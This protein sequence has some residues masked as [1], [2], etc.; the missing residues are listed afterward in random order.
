M[1]VNRSEAHIGSTLKGDTM[2]KPTKPVAQLRSALPELPPTLVSN[3]IE[4]AFVPANR[5]TNLMG[6]VA[7]YGLFG[8][9]ALTMTQVTRVNAAPALPVDTKTGDFVIVEIGPK[10]EPVQ[11]Q[12]LPTPKIT[13][14]TTRPADW[15]PLDV[16]N[17]VPTEAPTTVPTKDDSFSLLYNAKMPVGTG[18]IDKN[19]L[20]VLVKQGGA[21]VGDPVEPESRVVDFSYS[22]LRV[23]KQASLTYPPLARIARIQGPVVLVMTIDAGGVPTDVQV[24]SGP[25]QLQAEAVRC[26]KAWRFEPALVNGHPVM[27]RFNLTIQFRLS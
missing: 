5:L 4:G 13:V 2:F 15:K 25:P 20:D 7:L 16:V 23:L 8:M 1:W 22:N 3:P 21:T 26:A 11:I 24:Q 9:T 19:A 12:S 18:E 14:A 27:A 17:S 10:K 6:S